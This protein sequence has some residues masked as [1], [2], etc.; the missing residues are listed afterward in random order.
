MSLAVFSAPRLGLYVL[1]L[2]MDHYALYYKLLEK[3]VYRWNF[4][5]FGK[6]KCLFKDKINQKWKKDLSHF[7]YAFGPEAWVEMLLNGAYIFKLGWIIF[8]GW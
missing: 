4:A 1:K 5:L 6:R 3:P 7:L 8:L 2:R